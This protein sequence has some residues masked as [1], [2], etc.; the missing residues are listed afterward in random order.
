MK[1]L[2]KAEHRVSVAHDSNILSD[3][4][5]N[6]SVRALPITELRST[7]RPQTARSNAHVS[8]VNRSSHGQFSNLEEKK[9]WISTQ[10]KEL[11]GAATPKTTY[12][13]RKI[14]SKEE[15]VLYR[16][17]LTGRR[18][19]KGEESLERVCRGRLDRE[20]E[21]EKEERDTS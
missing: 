1:F 8:A 19:E 20:R 11:C 6:A 7:L 13:R 2:A 21:R 3:Y 5:W 14:L 17:G 15:R 18:R 10:T 9:K 12:E 16:K 4:W